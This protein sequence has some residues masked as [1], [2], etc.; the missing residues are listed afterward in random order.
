MQDVTD[1]AFMTLMA[2][3]GGPDVYWTEYLRVHAVSTPEKWIVQSIKE[4]ATGRPIV[5]QMIGNDIPSLVRTAKF[6]QQLP[7]AAIDLNLGCPAPVVYRKCAGGGLLREPA[8]VDAILG[9]LREAVTIPFTV[10]TRLGFDSPAVFDELLPI[11]ARHSLDLLTVHAR[12]VLEMYRSEVH[13]D[14]IARAVAAM[15]CPVMANGNVYSAAK[16]AEVLRHTG[17]RGLM[18]GRG[19]IRNP[20]LFT[21]I[22]QHQRG[23]PLF[24]PRGR[25]VLGYIRALYD[26]VCTPG[27]RESSQVQKMKKY[28]NYVGLGVDAEGKFLHQIRRVTTSAEFFRACEAFL[29]HD[30]A[31]SLEPFPIALKETDLL[32]GEHL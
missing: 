15:P 19:A 10:K 6:L 12:T 31:M 13:Y 28:L 2:R 8:R 20:W 27:I 3:Y 29:D 9:A 32:A 21:Q 7:V 30:R 1:R 26:A 25:D 5:A 11:F 23:E 14:F 16:A 4:N 17:A 18:I 24:V 22:R